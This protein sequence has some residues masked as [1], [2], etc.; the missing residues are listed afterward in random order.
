MGQYGI[1]N[2]EMNG[3]LMKLEYDVCVLLDIGMLYVLGRAW[4][5]PITEMGIANRIASSDS[6]MRF[7][8][9][10]DVLYSLGSG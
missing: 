5:G 2:G 4:S 8:R 9:S 6:R 1:E 7:L 10:I 3:I